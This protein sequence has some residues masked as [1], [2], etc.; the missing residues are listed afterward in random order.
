MLTW[1]HLCLLGTQTSCKRWWAYNL[2]SVCVLGC[3][4]DVPHYGEIHSTVEGLRRVTPHQGHRQCQSLCDDLAFQLQKF[5][6]ETLSVLLRVQNCP[7]GLR[8]PKQSIAVTCLRTQ[9]AVCHCAS[10]QRLSTWEKERENSVL[11]WLS[12]ISGVVKAWNWTH[13]SLLFVSFQER[14]G[15]KQPGGGGEGVQGD[16]PSDPSS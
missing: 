12:R 3:R 15:R 9:A 8:F 11:L 10:R 13:F 4:G 6:G 14:F 16:M 5:T 7:V 1:S 2:G